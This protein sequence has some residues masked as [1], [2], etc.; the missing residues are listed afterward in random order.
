[1]RIDIVFD[2]FRNK[3]TVKLGGNPVGEYSVFSRCDGKP[4]FS[5]F[6]NIPEYCRAEANETYNVVFRGGKL[7][8]M[9]LEAVLKEDS[10]CRGFTY[11]KELISVENRMSWIRDLAPYLKTDIKKTIRIDGPNADKN[12]AAVRSFIT[13]FT[14]GLLR[15]SSDSL[16]PDIVFAKDRS[17]E[18]ALS[19][20][21]KPVCLLV[22]SSGKIRYI[23]ISG[24]C[25]VFSGSL[26][27]IE[28][29]LNQWLEETVYNDLFRLA[30]KSDLNSGNT[31]LKKKQSMLCA[32]QPYVELQLSS[33]K[34]EMSETAQWNVIRL[35]ENHPCTVETD[36]DDIIRL[37]EKSVLKPL[38]PGKANITVF[39]K[40]VPSL[41]DSREITVY[42]FYP[43]TGLTLSR[44]AGQIV[45]NQKVTISLKYAPSNAMNTSDIRWS[46]SPA[47]ILKPIST[48]ARQGNFTAVKD[49]HCTVS[50]KAGHVTDQIAID[51]MPSPE[52]I[53]LSTDDLKLKQGE[54]GVYLKYTI[55]P[56]N[57]VGGS[58]DYSFSNPSV[59]KVDQRTG[60]VIAYN[61]GIC[62]VT[63]TLMDSNG[64]AVEEDRCTIT[65]LPPKDIYTPSLADAAALLG[66]L[67][68]IVSGSNEL[69]YLFEI[70][71]VIASVW[72][73]THTKVRWQYYLY[74]AV[75]GISLSVMILKI[76]LR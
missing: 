4:F 46:V 62:T 24:S 32:Y 65:V 1:M 52:K 61:E 68:V 48:N 69:I 34:I 27:N 40:I 71:A 6:R 54:Q 33:S 64:Y 36:R 8:A 43:V 2:R 67:G 73:V 12:A 16:S 44:P 58:V 35:P 66:L 11:E 57:A 38:K 42:R 29:F 70:I 26:N 37:D 72:G 5:W 7:E 9:M 55:L 15:V 60:E 13:P 28:D 19:G 18:P 31:L 41:R 39:S 30:E 10:Q 45:K 3:N 76:Y 59:A 23:S 51:V 21:D 22:S 74:G 53:R 47:D 50:V 17:R 25:H 49:G 75:I 63:A 14:G 20:S 56:A